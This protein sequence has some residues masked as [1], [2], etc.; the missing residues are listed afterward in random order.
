MASLSIGKDTT[1][2]EL[3]R[4][5]PQIQEAYMKEQEK[6]GKIRDLDIP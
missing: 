1:I 4:D 5:H 6:Q 2:R 3:L